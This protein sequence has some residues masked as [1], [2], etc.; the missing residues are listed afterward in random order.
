MKINTESYVYRLY[1][2][3]NTHTCIYFYQA[4]HMSPEQKGRLIMLQKKYMALKHF[5]V[6]LSLLTIISRYR[7]TRWAIIINYRIPYSAKWQNF[8]TVFKYFGFG[9]KIPQLSMR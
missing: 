7:Y 4:M 5:Q 8:V 6:T 2:T 3:F 1:D 9:Q